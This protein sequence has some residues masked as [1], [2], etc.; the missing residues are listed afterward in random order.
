MKNAWNF[1]SQGTMSINESNLDW[2]KKEESQEE[3]IMLSLDLQKIKINKWLKTKVLVKM[4][5]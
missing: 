2:I 1:G 4:K 5:K 3:V